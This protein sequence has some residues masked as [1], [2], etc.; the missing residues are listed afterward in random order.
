MNY[1]IDGYNLLHQVRVIRSRHVAPHELEK[2]RRSLIGQLRG[3]FAKLPGQ[4]KVVFDA[5]RAPGDV[6]PRVTHHGIEIFFTLKE[7]A[8]DFIERLID[9]ASNPEEWT[10]VSNDA[11]LREAARWKGC[12]HMDCLDFWEW[13]Q[14][15]PTEETVQEE[16]PDD[17]SADEIGWR[18]KEFEG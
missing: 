9:E 3:K 4:V 12:P 14:R 18:R 13:V 10:V 8:D 2:G 7:E 17:R 1:I 6:T 15:R 5:M 11:R 16:K